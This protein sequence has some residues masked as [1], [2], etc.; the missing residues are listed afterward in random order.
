[1]RTAPK[2]DSAVILLTIILVLITHNL[3][4]GVIAGSLLNVILKRNHQSADRVADQ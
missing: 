3:A 2:A 1:M 4:V